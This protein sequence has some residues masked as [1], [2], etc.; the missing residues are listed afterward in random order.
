MGWTTPTTRATGFLVTASVWNTDLVDNLAYLKGQAG[1]V[2][3]ESGIVSD[4]HN[5]DDLGTAAKEWKAGYFVNLF[6]GRFKAGP[7]IR[8]VRIPWETNTV[9]GSKPDVQ[10]TFTETG[11]GSE[12]RRGGTGQISM[13]VDNDAGGAR[14]CEIE[15]ESEISP[16]LD[17]QWFVTNKPYMRVE[18]AMD[19]DLANAEIFIG[20]RTTPGGDRPTTEHHAGIQ[21]TGTQWQST[22]AA[23]TQ[24]TEALSNAPVQAGRNIVEIYINSSTDLEIW[25]NGVRQTVITTNLPTSNMDWQ[26]LL[27][28][29]GAGAGDA[30]MTVGEII[31]QQASA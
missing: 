7:N 28:T 29:D 5:T 10:V 25:I 30:V 23:G 12:I 1:V 4:T 9:T 20:F 24:G 15:Q 13:K 8:E 18:F 19:V 27:Q 31:L 14:S 16:A 22:H 21:W 6:A 11:A 17:N 26:V 3:L 2:E